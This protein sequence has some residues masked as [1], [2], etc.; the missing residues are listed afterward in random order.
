MFRRQESGTELKNQIREKYYDCQQLFND[1]SI[2][3]RTKYN[4]LMTET[5]KAYLAYVNNTAHGNTY[6]VTLREKLE[7]LHNQLH[8]HM[9]CDKPVPGK[10]AT[11]RE[12]NSFF[13]H[14]KMPEFI[15]PEEDNEQLL[16]YN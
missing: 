15:I 4:K 9:P 13:A 16:E 1:L 10:D 11:A 14:P 2:A 3:E 6:F 5:R 12:L 7:E 8:D